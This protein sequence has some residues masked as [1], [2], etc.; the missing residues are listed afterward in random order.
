MALSKAHREEL[1][2]LYNALAD[3]VL[4][5]GDPRYEDQINGQDASGTDAVSA[6]ATEI[7]FQTGG[8]VCLFTG[9]RGTGKSTELKR[10]QAE[11]E[12]LGIVA[13]YAD[14]SEYVLLT[15]PIE[16]SDFLI[17]MAGAL[18]DRIHADQ[19][20]AKNPLYR[21]YWERLGHFLQSKVEFK[22]L[23]IKVE[24][25][26]DIKA[27]LKNDPDFKQRVQ[28]AARGH[29][30]QIVRDA[31]T[32]FADAVQMLRASSGQPDLKVVLIVDSIERIRGVGD[33]AM[34]VYE[35][36]RNLFFAHAEHLRIPPLHIVY[37][38]PPYLSVLAAGAGALM[39]GATVRRLV[40]THIFRDR[41]RDV[42]DS[43]LA[44][45]RNV[46][47]LRHATW[48]QLFQKAALDRLA[49]SSGGDLRE[50]FRLIRQCLPAVRD[51]AQLPLSVSAVAHT[52]TAARAEMLPIPS[53][54]LTWLKQIAATHDT[55]LKTND[56]LPLLAHFLDN[57]LV[58]NYRNGTDWYDVHP[59]LRDVVDA[60]VP[61]DPKPRTGS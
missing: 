34:A 61:A 45:M 51:D 24:G 8:G 46:I 27:S 16:I 14:L 48:A 47:G 31:H 60:H 50:F 37:T 15:K 2:T 10:L 19:R 20:F 13:F 21:N 9:Q 17:S 56:D 22:E 36:V 6:I 49:I 52:E 38:V 26:A 23:G 18:S 28:Q 53:D 4:E 58:M 32:F 35:S 41:S 7:D 59:L 3:N 1:K 12:K 40:S 42:D 30:A 43:G 54:Q 25:L 55:C 29:V 33:E 5:P 39:G 11:L 57:R 44:L